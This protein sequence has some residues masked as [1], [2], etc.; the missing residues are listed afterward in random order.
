[1]EEKIIELLQNLGEDGINA[2]YVYLFI[3]YSINITMLIAIILGVR[4]IWEKV[5][6]DWD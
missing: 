2:F 5:K 3:D 1:M 6:A 4:A